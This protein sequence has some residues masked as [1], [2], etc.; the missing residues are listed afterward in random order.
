M[1]YALAIA[2]AT[3]VFAAIIWAISRLQLVSN[4]TPGDGSET[5]LSELGL[6][7]IIHR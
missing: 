1:I 2:I 3:V 6:P 4:F 5:R 7:P